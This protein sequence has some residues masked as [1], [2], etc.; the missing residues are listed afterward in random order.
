[1]FGVVLGTIFLDEEKKKHE[2]ETAEDSEI[3]LSFGHN[4]L[5]PLKAV[6]A[7][8]GFTYLFVAFNAFFVFVD[9]TKMPYFLYNWA[10]RGLFM[11][12]FAGII[13]L[14][15]LEKDCLL[16]CIFNFRP[17]VIIGT[18]ASYGVYIF[19]TS[20]FTYTQT[21]LVPAL[22][23]AGIELAFGYWALILCGILLIF[24]VL[25]HNL[26]EGPISFLLQTMYR[27]CSKSLKKRAERKQRLKDAEWL[28][29]LPVDPEEA[30]EEAKVVRERSSTSETFKVTL[31]YICM[32]G[33]FSM[34]AI[35][36]IWR[37]NRVT[38]GI[39]DVE[40]SEKANYA[41]NLIK[42]FAVIAIPALLFNISGHLLF[43]PAR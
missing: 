35:W 18:Q 16:G 8:V 11:L 19:Q 13:W 3:P 15:S 17:F 31:Y 36:T 4:I 25:I 26:F 14:A 10:D 39:V 6:L 38:N 41:I 21:F 27:K 34:F 42:I 5:G 1:M 37:P 30:R 33:V 28:E 22:E 20:A 24:S 2:I 23:R 40:D 32:L 12:V 7:R 9:I 29:N 43:P